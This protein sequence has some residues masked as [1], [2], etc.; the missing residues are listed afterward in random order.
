VGEHYSWV[1][2][3]PS[4]VSELGKLGSIAS[5]F[6]RRDGHEIPDSGLCTGESATRKEPGTLCA[7]RLH[8]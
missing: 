6:G 1:A 5:N 2:E 3:L 7:E 8:V 4:H